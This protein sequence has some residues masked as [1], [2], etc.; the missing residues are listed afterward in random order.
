MKKSQMEI[1]GIA[2]VVIIISIV[3]VFVIR[4]AILQKPAEHKKE[5]AQS[6]IA[7]NL[8]NTLLSTTTKCKGMTFNELFQDCFENWP[9]GRTDCTE[10]G[11]PNSCIYL[12]FYDAA[13]KTETGELVD[14]FA[15]TLGAWHYNYTFT[16]KHEGNEIEIDKCGDIIERKAK[17]YLIPGSIEAILAICG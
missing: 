14:I 1:M 5:F 3:I 15:D 2:I 8:V 9:D 12:Y 13:L 17:T 7:T 10:S 16:V 4:F 6:E 11:S